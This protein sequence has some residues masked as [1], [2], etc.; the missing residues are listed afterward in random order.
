MKKCILFLFLILNVCVSA[1][2]LPHYKLTIAQTDL[3]AMYASPKDEQYY[4][5]VFEVDTFKYDVLARFKGSTT[6]GYPKKSWAIK[7]NN[8][9]NYFGV[10][11]INLHADYKDDSKMRN[12]LI[13]N[14][15]D[16]MGYPA[17]QIKHVTY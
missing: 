9:K 12:F 15:F 4:P 6:L 3:D 11:R 2:S 17:S 1:A 14:L 16:F 7:F 5:A 8:K 13:M 10:S